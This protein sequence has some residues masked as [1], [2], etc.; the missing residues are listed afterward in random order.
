MV[1][2]YPLFFLKATHQCWGRL[3]ERSS[4]LG[5]F[6]YF[7]V[8][9]DNFNDINDDDVNVIEHIDQDEKLPT[10]SGSGAICALNCFFGLLFKPLPRCMVIV[11]Y[12]FHH[13][14][15]NTTAFCV[16]LLT[17]LFLKR[18]R[19]TVSS[20]RRWGRSRLTRTA[21]CRSLSTPRMTLTMSISSYYY[22]TW[23]TVR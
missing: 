9:A 5:W 4:S 16:C 7:F 15:H 18:R 3:A 19:T 20:S 17:L 12:L 14:Q 13:C 1:F 6:K 21:C 23:F 2:F 11:H 8:V 22:N 10:N